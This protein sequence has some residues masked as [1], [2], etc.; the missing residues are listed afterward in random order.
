MNYV[1]EPEIEHD[2]SSKEDTADYYLSPEEENSLIRAKTVEKE[3]AEQHIEFTD[4]YQ[5]TDED[6]L[7]ASADKNIEKRIA[8]RR[9]ALENQQITVKKDVEPVELDSQLTGDIT[10]LLASV[11]GQNLNIK[12]DPVVSQSIQ[13]DNTNERVNESDKKIAP[14][15]PEQIAEIKM[16]L[17]PFEN[18]VVKQEQKEKAENTAGLENNE[19]DLNKLADTQGADVSDTRL[20]AKVDEAKAF[21]AAKSVAIDIQSDIVKES[22][23]KELKN[24]KVSSRLQD[25]ADEAD[26]QNQD[27]DVA[28]YD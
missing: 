16:D 26:R 18:S 21:D 8:E 28:S 2:E 19:D 23:H 24:T 6:I 27:E 12:N 10:N 25:I 22:E 11:T 15:M 1:T 7:I 5:F 4:D 17:N 14:D 9:K 3:K 13:S 20:Q